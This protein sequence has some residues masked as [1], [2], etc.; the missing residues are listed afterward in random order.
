MFQT[1]EG[2][3]LEDR[4][5]ILE[6]G[7]LYRPRTTMHHIALLYTCMMHYIPVQK[8]SYQEGVKR[9]TIVSTS[10]PPRHLNKLFRHLALNAQNAP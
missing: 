4:C 9:Q 10:A 1:D 8:S 6:A 5:M 3:S 2:A 7:I